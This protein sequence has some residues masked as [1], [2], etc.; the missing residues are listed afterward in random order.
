MVLARLLVLLLA[1]AIAVCVA[2]GI[3][4]G[5]PEHYARAW[6]LAKVGLA[7]A[8]IFFVVLIVSRIV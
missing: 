1:L 5:R 4:T 2:M 8:C 6:R 7:A 3:L